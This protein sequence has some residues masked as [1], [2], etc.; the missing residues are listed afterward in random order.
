[1]MNGKKRSFKKC[2]SMILVVSMVLMFMPVTALAAVE[3][4]LDISSGSIIINT[5]GYY[6]ITQSDNST[7]TA[8]TI[9]VNASG[10]VDIT[11]QA[12]NI[13]T[14]GCAFLIQS[15]TVNLTLSGNNTLVSTENYAGLQ[16]GTN[17]LTIDGSGSLYA[18]CVTT[19]YGVGA[20]IGGGDWSD[21][22]NIT[23]N[24]GAITAVGGNNSAGIGG[25]H[26]GSGSNITING[27]TVTAE[28][29]G[30]YGAGIGGGCWNDGSNITINGGTVVAQ[31]AYYGA[32]IGGGM[33]GS[34]SN[35]TI[36][37]G[38]VRAIGG[39]TDFTGKRYDIGGGLN[40]GPA[41]TPMNANG[42]NVYL[43]TTNNLSESER[44]IL[45]Q[46]V[47]SNPY[48]NLTDAN[49]VEGY[50]YL[51]L[52]Q[53]SITYNNIDG[54]TNTNPNNFNILSNIT[55]VEASKSGYLFDGW[56][57]SEGNQVASI[58]TGTKG[59]IILNAVWTTGQSADLT[60]I[61][62]SGNPANYTFNG[63]T[64]NYEGVT[65]ASNITS[66]TV[67]PSGS[68]TITVD[69]TEI[70]SENKSVEI[71]LKA[72]LE[73]TITIV[74]TET[75]KTPVTYKIIVTRLQDTQ[76]TP[77]FSPGSGTIAYGS[78]VTITSAGADH[79]YYT[80]DG[81][82]PATT[83]GGSTMEYTVPITVNDALTI[84][85]IAVKAG[86]LNSTIGSANYTQ[87]ETGDLTDIALS[88]NPSNY[89]FN[90]STYIYNG[91]RV[92]NNVK[93]II[94]TPAGIG[95]ITV[96]GIEVVSG[97]SSGSIAL[98]TGVEKKITVVATETGKSPKTYTI[99]ITRGASSNATLSAMSISSGTLDPAFASATTSYTA[100]VVNNVSSLTVT[101]TAAESN[102]TITVN[103]TAVSSGQTSSPMSLTVGNNVI[104]VA[105]AAQD[106]KTN[107][108]YTITVTREASS[109]ATLSGLTISSGM[110]V[111]Q[112]TSATE[113]YKTSV[114]NAVKTITV[115][116]TATES[117]S[118]ITVNGK[119]VKSGIASKTIKL[120]V[121]SNTIIIAVTAQDKTTTKIYSVTVNRAN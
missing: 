112:F 86:N 57:D 89:T 63:S 27:G 96:N 40:G 38:S 103:G 95:T 51:Y 23:I 11:L 4:S 53:Y 108:K 9:T 92:A 46:E 25:G 79:I 75:E 52:P 65:V 69:G 2:L 110:L 119:T 12:V 39:Y 90:R 68:G 100:S 94:V 113:S 42:E 61:A 62:L 15:G 87:A 109:D 93:S 106:G 73:K 8:N 83:V 76:A 6:S 88:G 7:S 17:Q 115:T 70:T 26:A 55:F 14:S 41:V 64:Y 19:V 34:C 99:Y 74:A 48:Y 85:A 24:G 30:Y 54:A 60:D 49:P 82:D 91:L 18:Q 97:Q 5:P 1:M 28:G 47:N 43:I 22:S 58:A 13:Q 56:F 101:P 10:T 33:N 29:T 107:M 72:G 31:G 81:T 45:S 116:P 20:G 117:N 120:D 50:Y 118:T 98:A 105:V 36:N 3:T 59:N 80:T 32:G 37:G 66:I 21:G 16:N 67:T 84:K 114:G 121:G 111:P 102:A 104:N 35:V 78:T 44:D 77:S 71:T